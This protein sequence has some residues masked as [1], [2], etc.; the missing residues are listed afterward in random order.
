MMRLM[1]GIS[2]FLT[3][4]PGAGAQRGGGFAHPMPPI[5]SPTGPTCARPT[6][7]GWGHHPNNGFGFN[8]PVIPYVVPYPL[9]L[10]NGFTPDNPYAYPPGQSGMPISQPNMPIVMAPQPS[11]PPAVI[12]EYGA[13]AEPPPVSDSAAS[14]DSNVQTYVAPS[15]PRPEPPEDSSPT[16]FIALKDGSVY[17]TNAYWVQDGTLYY[18]TA[19]GAHNQVS[20]DLLDRKISAKLNGRELWLPR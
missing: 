14:D 7:P 11:A 15:S 19:H 1:A 18:L 20:L 10:G 16:F 13:E 12:N 4:L 6:A 5:A 2:L 3:F 17:T 8:R 9:Y